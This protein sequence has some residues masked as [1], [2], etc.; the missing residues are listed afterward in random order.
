MSTT[1][2]KMPTVT[3]SWE[4]RQRLAS[5]VVD[6]APAPPG[7][8][9]A[10][11]W[12]IYSLS[13]PRN[14]RAYRYVGQTRWPARRLL[15]HVLSAHAAAPPASLDDGDIAW[16]MTPRERGPLQAWILEL[17]AEGQR[18]PCMVVHGWEQSAREAIEAERR[19]I[20]ECLRQ[21]HALFNAEARKRS[22]A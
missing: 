16:W 12:A 10:E 18:L 13:D 19:M 8:S 4:L 21:G 6:D 22:W 7:G 15:Q 17:H 3:A 11:A 14:L 5:H 1:G 9:R 20:E 2:R